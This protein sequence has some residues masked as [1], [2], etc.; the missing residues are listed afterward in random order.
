MDQALLLI[1]RTIGS[2]Y[3]LLIL[4]RF[5]LHAAGADFYNPVCQMIV[6]ATGPGLRPFRKIIPG[7]RRLDFAALMFALVFNFLM[8][9]LMITVAGF[10]LPGLGVILSWSLVGVLGFTLDIYFY[11]LL[12]SIVASWLAPHSGNPLLLV[13]QQM[14]EP[15]QSL[16]RKVIPPMGGLDFSPIFIFLVIQVLEVMLVQSFVQGLRLPRQLVLGV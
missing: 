12:I 5:L 15:I 8:T 4:A 10:N 2:L 14:L 9:A 13:V 16:F 3:L 11:G 7:F 1:I 6:K